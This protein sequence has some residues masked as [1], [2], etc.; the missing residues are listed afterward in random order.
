MHS[1][2]DHISA[3]LECRPLA[4]E[5]E[6]RHAGDYSCYDE[7]DGATLSHVVG[8]LLSLSSVPTA[9]VT[10]VGTASHDHDDDDVGVE[11]VPDEEYIRHRCRVYKQTVHFFAIVPRRGADEDADDDADGCTSVRPTR[12]VTVRLAKRTV[13][14][15]SVAAQH[16]ADDASEDVWRDT[17]VEIE[18]SDGQAASL[19]EHIPYEAVSLVARLMRCAERC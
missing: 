11:L 15:K 13:N 5:L 12:L 7:G 16:R 10:A 8:A 19:C 9:A 1:A 18:Q 6:K 17:A 4:N 2:L 3:L 14:G